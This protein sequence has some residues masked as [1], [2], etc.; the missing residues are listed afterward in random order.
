MKTYTS[1]YI[2]IDMYI[3][4]YMCVGWVGVGVDLAVG[5]DVDVGVG[6]CVDLVVGVGE[7][8][9]LSVKRKSTHLINY[10]RKSFLF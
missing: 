5:M 1:I 4:T 7:G 8:V 6:V 2:H 10:I 3:N 9:S